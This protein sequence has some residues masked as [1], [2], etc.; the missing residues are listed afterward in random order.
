[1]LH[2]QHR[3]LHLVMS[4]DIVELL[5]VTERTGSELRRVVAVGRDSSDDLVAEGRLCRKH[6]HQLPAV[7]RVA[8][9]DRLPQADPPASKMPDDN[10]NK[11]S[12]KTE[13]AGDEKKVEK[14][15]D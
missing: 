1:M 6:V 4:D 8:D 2:R 7:R 10:P 11:E 5:D 14:Q 9:D 15:R 12:T 13:T 3:H